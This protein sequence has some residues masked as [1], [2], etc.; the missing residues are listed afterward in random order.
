MLP[1]GR[2]PQSSVHTLRLASLLCRLILWAKLPGC[3]QPTK[4]PEMY[5][6]LGR[7]IAFTGGPAPFRV[8]SL[9]RSLLPASLGLEHKDLHTHI[10]RQTGSR[11]HREVGKGAPTG[12]GGPLTGPER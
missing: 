11:P 6:E 7:C 5:P 12:G 3:G 10:N 9:G 1:M 4:E 8:P 2:V